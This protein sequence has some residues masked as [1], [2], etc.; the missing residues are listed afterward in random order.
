MAQRRQSRTS[1]IRERR[2]QWWHSRPCGETSSS[3]GMGAGS[4]TVP[5]LVDTQD[6]AA[7]ELL[8]P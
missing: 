1:H 8:R 6:A 4:A 7:G 5:H 3:G 2:H